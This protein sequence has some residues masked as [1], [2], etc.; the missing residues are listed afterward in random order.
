VRDKIVC[1]ICNKG[2]SVPKSTI[3]TK[4]VSVPKGYNLRLHY[5]TSHKDA[6]GV[7]KK[8]W[9]DKL[10][11]L[12]TDLQWQR[13]TFIKLNQMKY[14]FMQVLLFHILL[15]INQ[16]QSSV[17]RNRNIFILTCEN[18]SPLCLSPLS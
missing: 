9:E 7:L 12:K 14:Q 5:E 3:C 8:P 10:K 11:S 17:E 4:G 13:N 16:N 1:L 2:V 6:F 15:Q 18:K